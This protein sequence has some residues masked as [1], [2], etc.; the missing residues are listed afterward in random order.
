MVA[1]AGQRMVKFQIAEGVEGVAMP[2]PVNLLCSCGLPWGRI[3]DDI[4]YVRSRHHGEVHEN[5]CHLFGVRLTVE[6]ENGE[7]AKD[8]EVLLLCKRSDGS[9]QRV[10]ITN[11]SIPVETAS[12][13]V[14]G[15]IRKS[16]EK[17]GV[18]TIEQFDIQEVSIIP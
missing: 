16:S 13:G 10:T 2:D 1:V 12:V 3:E 15:I 4:L 7:R 17:D 6:G 5:A 14:G 18:R 8:G 11:V 9:A